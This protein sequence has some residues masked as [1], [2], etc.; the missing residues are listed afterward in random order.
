MV[1]GLAGLGVPFAA[2]YSSAGAPLATS[3][4]ISKVTIVNGAGTMPSLVAFSPD[5][6]KVIIGV[7]N[8]VE[9]TDQDDT[10]DVN[11]YLPDHVLAA[12][13]SSFTS[14]PLNPGDTFNF[15]FTTPGTYG[16][17]CN[18]HPWMVGS[19]IVLGPGG[20]TASSSV[21]PTTSTTALTT[22]TTTTSP[23]PTPVSQFPVPFA[24]LGAALACC[25]VA[26]RLAKGG[27]PADL[28]P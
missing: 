12:N 9:W 7:N 25:A 14:P 15:T 26:Y 11:G 2:S 5:I 21:T 24:V 23:S 4:Q 1:A 3:P 8:T 13:D 20:T 18:V 28:R 22:S 27:P 16:Y 10:M 6:I 19:V 17:H